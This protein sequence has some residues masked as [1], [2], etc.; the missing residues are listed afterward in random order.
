MKIKITTAA[1]VPEEVRSIPAGVVVITREDIETY[2][3]ATLTGI[4]QNIPGLYAVDDYAD[5]GAKFGVRGFWT[6][7]ANDNIIILV[8]GVQQIYDAA[9]SYPLGISPIPVEAIDRIEVVK[10]PMSVIYGS[11]AFFGVINIF[12][13]GGEN[14]PLNMVSVSAGS[15]TTKK[16]LLRLE[17]QEGDFRYTFNGA[18][19]DT[20]GIDEPLSKMMSDPT[21]LPDYNVPAD[22]RT[23]GQLETGRK[24]FNISGRMKG[25][26][27]D[28]S[29]SENNEELFFIIPSFADGI[30][31]NMTSARVSVGYQRD[32]SNIFAV[33]GKFNYSHTRNWYKYDHLSPDFYGI[34]ELKSNAFS[35]ELNAF[36]TPSSRLD[37]KAGL[38]YRAILDVDNNYD[39]P[40]FGSPTLENNYFFLADDDQIVTRAI[41]TQI[42]YKPFANLEL[43]AGVRLE[44]MPKYEMV[45]VSGGGTAFAS[46]ARHTY[47]ADAVEI[48]PRFAAIYSVDDKNIFKILYGK[49]TN[50]PSFLQNSRNS[51]SGGL[52]ELEP[53]SIQTL[54][55]NYIGVISS[56]FTLNASIFANTLEN[57]ITR[58]VESD[59]NFNY[60]TWSAN[61]GKMITKGLEVTLQARP[62]RHFNLEL[63][64]TFQKTTDKREGF[65]G[66]TTEYSPDFLGYVKASYKFKKFTAALTGFYVDNMETYWDETIHN[67]NNTFGNRIG[68]R[69]P[70]YFNLGANLRV[71]D[72]LMKG[73]AVSV[74]VSNLLDEEIR[75]PTFTNNE[76]LDRGSL[77]HGRT[78]LVSAGWKW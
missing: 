27:L 44:Q 62:F 41:Y 42:A 50:R 22:M 48:I 53:E 70:G 66:I 18:L 36:I 6:G 16:L 57:L 56:S 77:G 78:F 68:E 9:S 31:N 7:V 1:R 5:H 49:A 38:S 61:A 13:N 23:G 69:A 11:G 12:T 67:P 17:G 24:Y 10:G 4:L 43:V 73:L 3:Y 47:N 37:I 71:E 14:K 29:Y 76:W 34:Q 52:V 74:R 26:Y 54:E 64:A 60:K 63:S 33:A 2:G 46:T 72:F 65:T 51:F 19:Y 32:L 30:A 28:F 55:I 75:Y 59:E 40:S 15:E 39:L 35:L 58:V 45:A 25:V 8:N 21:I 20:R